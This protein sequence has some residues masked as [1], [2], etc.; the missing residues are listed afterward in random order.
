MRKKG[1]VSY[2][3]V[4]CVMAVLFLAVF[5]TGSLTLNA[6]AARYRTRY[7]IGGNEPFRC[8]EEVEYVHGKKAALVQRSYSASSDAASGDS[9]DFFLKCAGQRWGYNQLGSKTNGAKLQ[10]YYDMIFDSMISVWNSSVDIKNAKARED[11]YNYDLLRVVYSDLGITKEQAKEVYFSFIYDNPIFYFISKTYSTVELKYDNG[12]TA[13]GIKF[14]IYKEYLDG[15]TRA[16]YQSAIKSY[17]ASAVKDTQ[18][19]TS[20][21]RNALKLHEN[22]SYDMDYSKTAGSPLYSG[23]Y[24]AAHNVTGG[25]SYGKGVCESYAKIYQLICSYCG[26]DC[27]YVVGKGK[28]RSGNVENHAWNMVRL[29]DGKYYGVDVTWD[30]TS[31]DL[32]SFAKGTNTFNRNHTAQ[33][34]G[35]DS[36]SQYMYA[37]P[38]NL[39]TRDFEIY[40]IRTHTHIYGTWKTTKS[41]TCTEAGLETRTCATCGHVETRTIEPKG[42]KFTDKVVAPTCT[43]D[44]YTEHKCSVCGETKK[45]TVVKATGH[46]FVDKVVPPTTEQKGYTEH[47]CSVCGYSY[48]DKETPKLTDDNFAT[49]KLMKSK[50]DPQDIDHKNVTVTVYDAGGSKAAA[51]TVDDKRVVTLDKKLADGS[52]KAV[53]EM[54]GFASRSVEFTVKNG[55]ASLG[56][57]LIC[58]YGDLNGDGSIDFY[59]IALYQQVL[60]GWDVAPVYIE[61]ADFDGNGKME[62]RELGLL[63]QYICGW[64]ITLGA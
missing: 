8:T 19:Q 29:E 24:H 52:Y 47:T 55:K 37:L 1:S 51:G 2:I 53:F 3:R 42:H 12:K 39:S 27:V 13:S 31:G 44:G 56:E 43:A 10:K 63:Q 18:S 32:S 4:F 50:K 11:G 62:M 9:R 15:K 7:A 38:S 33:S 30:D 58:H 34:S 54:T 17:L 49:V 48:R 64:D 35:W 59:D 20:L 5:L 16:K 57:I 23:Y 61:A 28:S 46:K 26:I 21:Y 45:D 60:C 14:Y 36:D 40:M 41:A 22:I 6:S 25:I